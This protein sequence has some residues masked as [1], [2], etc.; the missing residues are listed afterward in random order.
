M[1]GLELHFFKQAGQAVEVESV[2]HEYPSEPLFVQDIVG[3]TE[4]GG[5]EDGKLL[6]NIEE[7]RWA[8]PI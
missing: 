3:S 7:R 6:R 5:S 1:P 4:L 2:A 8:Q